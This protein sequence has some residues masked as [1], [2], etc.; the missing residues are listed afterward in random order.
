MSGEGGDHGY[1]GPVL[2]S[3]NITE[4]AA[5]YDQSQ[6]LCG[7]ALSIGAGADAVNFNI[8]DGLEPAPGAAPHEGSG[9]VIGCVLF[10]DE[11]AAA[12]KSSN[13]S[14][15][16]E[17]RKNTILEEGSE[18]SFSEEEDHAHHSTSTSATT[19]TAVAVLVARGKR[20]NTGGVVS[21]NGGSLIGFSGNDENSAIALGGVGAVAI[22][23]C[24]RLRGKGGVWLLQCFGY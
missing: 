8:L 6:Q 11:E 5:Q 9:A 24:L 15:E 17:G 3:A 18:E 12:D 13:G 1:V 10:G 7:M 23:R 22:S 20:A 4:Y 16:W 14:S 2:C 21:G 19:R